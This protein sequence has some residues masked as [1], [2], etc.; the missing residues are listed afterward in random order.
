MEP[1][2]GAA[3]EDVLDKCQTPIVRHRKTPVNIEIIALKKIQRSLPDKPNG[4][5]T[6]SFLDENHVGRA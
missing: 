3:I 1:N 4:L 5:W 2:S 6:Y